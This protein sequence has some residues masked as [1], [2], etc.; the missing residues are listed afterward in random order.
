MIETQINVRLDQFDGPLGLLLH[1]I[2]KE[3]IDI[4]DLEINTITNQYLD[5]LQKLQDVNFDVAGEYLYLAASLLY[6]KSKN[7]TEEQE[8]KIKIEG[9]GELEITTKTQLIQKL[10]ELARF[11]KLGEKLMNLPR[12]DEDIFVKPKVDK[13]SIQNSILLPMDLQTLTA[14][15]IDIM[16]Q[17][18][19]KYTVV[20][21]DRLSIKEKL[22]EL[23]NNLSIGSSTS[24]D[25]L[26]NWEKGRDEVVITF[27][28]LLELA[29]LQKLDI[30]QNE[31]DGAIYVEVLDS[32]DTF[33]IETADG[34]D[35]EDEEGQVDE[36]LLTEIVLN[37]SEAITNTIQ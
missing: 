24:M 14:A 8:E 20:R 26:I 31:R 2:Q 21:R 7:V 9:L 27:I 29:R 15:M 13:K 37:E 16:K 32:L 10:E 36:S 18:K 6:I 1:L 11:Q 17:E 12:R 23:K 35:P 5:Y 34:F 33:D 25:K 19:R 30:F 28:S 4:K 22:I 3:E